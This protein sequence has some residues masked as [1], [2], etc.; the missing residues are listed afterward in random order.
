MGLGSS[1]GV[2]SGD[3]V[4][5]VSTPEIL[6][7][8]T[9]WLAGAFCLGCLILSFATSYLGKGGEQDPLPQQHVEDFVQDVEE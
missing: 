1:F 6:K 4:F 2:D 7:K 5:G 9:G 8:V 3:S